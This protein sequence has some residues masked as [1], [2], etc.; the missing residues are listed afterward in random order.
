MKEK[1]TTYC[2]CK[3]GEV[4]SKQSSR[5]CLSLFISQEGTGE[6]LLDAPRSKVLA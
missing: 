5:Q 3:D 6:A 4:A 2:S 1:E